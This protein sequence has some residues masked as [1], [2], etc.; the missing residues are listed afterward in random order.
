MI[1][2]FEDAM[3][4]RLITT[5]ITGIN[6]IAY[7]KELRNGK[8]QPPYVHIFPDPTAID[9]SVALAITEE[10]F[11]RFTVMVVAASYKSQDG[12]QAE[13]LALEASMALM[14]DPATGLPERCLGGTVQDIVRAVWHANYTR[15]LPTEQLFGAATEMEARTLIREVT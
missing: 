13:Q 4:N 9:G 5:A 10:W 15:E 14:I 1:K 6:G 2:A 8:M 11:F 7:N 3:V 12:D